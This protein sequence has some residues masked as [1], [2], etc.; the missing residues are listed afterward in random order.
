MAQQDKRYARIQQKTDSTANWTKATNFKPLEGEIVVY[1]DAGDTVPKIKIGHADTLVSDLPFIT[2]TI[3]ADIDTLQDNVTQINKDIE[4]IDARIEPIELKNSKTNIAYA[5]CTTAASTAAKVATIQNNNSWVLEV[6]SII[7]VLYTNTNTVSNPTLKIGDEAAYPILYN[8]AAITS[9]TYRKYGGLAKTPII[10]IFDGTGYRFAGYGSD[11]ND[12]TKISVYRQGGDDDTTWDAD[13]PLIASRT[14]ASGIGSSTEGKATAVYG[15]VATDA[16]NAPTVNPHT[17]EV[18]V[19]SLEINGDTP[20]MQAVYEAKISDIYDIIENPTT[21]ELIAQGGGTRGD[22]W[23]SLISG[24]STNPLAADLPENISDKLIGEIHDGNQLYGLYA[25][26][27]KKDSSGNSIIDTYATKEA[28]KDV[29]N[30]YKAAIENVINQNAFSNIKIGTTTIEADDVTDTV[31]FEGSNITI[32]PDATNDKITFSVADGTTSAKGVVQLTDSVASSSTTTAATPKAVQ[33]A[34]D[35]AATAASAADAAQETANNAYELAETK[36]DAEAQAVSAADADKLGGK[37]PSYYATASDLSTV[38]EVADSANNQ[39]NTNKAAI[40]SIN[41]S[42]TTINGNADTEGSIANAV[43]NETT[44]RVNADDALGDRITTLETSVVAANGTVDAR[45]VAA[46]KKETDIRESADNAIETAYKEA[47]TKIRTDFATADAATL[48]SAK[49]DATTKADN[50]L[51]EAKKYADEIDDEVKAAFISADTNLQTQINTLNGVTSTSTGDTG[52]S[53]RTIANEEL[54]RVLINGAT[55]GAEDNFTTLKELADWLEQHPEDAAAMN[56]NILALIKEIYGDDT[57]PTN[58]ASRLDS[59]DTTIAGINSALAEKQ[60]TITG[61]AS[62]VVDNNLTASRVL[63]SNSSG[64]IA[65]SSSITTTE[66]GY[67][68][69]VSSNIQTQFSNIATTYATKNELGTETSARESEDTALG[70]R[71]STLETAVGS[72]GSVETKITKALDDA[73]EYADQSETDA[74]DSAN[75]YT[76]KREYAITQAY[77]AKIAAMN[78]VDT[79]VAKQL[80]SEVDQADGKITVTRRALVAADIPSHKSTATT[81]GVG[82][83]S[84]Y[85]HLK[86]SDAVDSTSSTSGG[87]AATPKAVQTVRDALNTLDSEVEALDAQVGKINVAYGTCTTAAATAEKVVEITGYTDWRLAAGSIITVLFTNTNTAASPTL[88]V[89]ETGAKPISYV[90]ATITSSNLTY[91]GYRNRPITY[92]Y[93]GEAYHFISWGYESGNTNTYMRTYRRGDSDYNKEYPLLA[94]NTQLTSLKDAEDAYDALYGLVPTTDNYAPTINP[95][96]GLVKLY[97]L[98]I[99]NNLN[100]VGKT[101]LNTLDIGGVTTHTGG[102]IYLTGS[103]ASSSTANTTQL[104]FGTS[105]T[106]HVALSANDNALVINPTTEDT[107]SQIVLYLNKQSSFPSG[108]TGGTITTTGLT[109]NGKANITGDSTLAALTTSGKATLNS[110]K[111][112]GESELVG[113]LKASSASFSSGASVE[114]QFNANSVAIFSET[115]GIQIGDGVKLLYDS[116]KKCLNFTF[117]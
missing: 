69:G 14:L 38:S 26:R 30:E 78:V 111:V 80:V 28:L 104:V 35:K 66:L 48:A 5:T 37:D 36:L 44:A 9:S 112:S 67:L 24:I 12:N 98:T 105:S 61:A 107:T 20:V 17:G 81:Y 51:S 25:V 114:G 108:I 86:L 6:G 82:D 109:V 90:N 10:Y 31:E 54:A 89:N 4:S 94:S 59:I 8:G 39:A 85:G 53:V 42:I 34:Y 27:A 11:A 100:V 58:G 117:L 93:D 43:A 70:N 62:T 83:A 115:Y 2:E 56:S 116:T 73:K 113:A 74:I 75:D 18:K 101:S 79:A 63:V 16:T 57:I 106:Q 84:N 103:S 52:K 99:N 7:I 45:I 97:N 110:L 29:E 46:V 68:N 40:E 13:Y 92:M 64:K 1:Q 32:T 41:S 50:A 77:T 95:Y 19:K 76:D 87:I 15:M 22:L 88:N 72:G 33:T 91:G 96:T 55:N 71:I 65:A 3:E 21:Y 102:H 23:L 49:K 47:D 60:A